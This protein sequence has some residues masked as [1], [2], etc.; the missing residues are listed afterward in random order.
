MTYLLTK[1]P[2]WFNHWLF[3][4][5]PNWSGVCICNFP[6]NSNPEIQSYH[7]QAVSTNCQWWANSLYYL[8]TL[9]FSW[10]LQRK[11]LK[12]CWPKYICAFVKENKFVNVLE[13]SQFLFENSMTYPN[14]IS[15][16][17]S[18]SINVTRNKHYVKTHSSKH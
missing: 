16:L 6:T 11:L 4:Y 13:Y 9:K 1:F 18:Y 3:K 7:L 12:F 14:I 10:M 8:G 2:W 5:S 17:T 15:P